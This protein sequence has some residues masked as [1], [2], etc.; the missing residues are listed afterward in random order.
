MGGG[1][2]INPHQDSREPRKFSSWDVRMWSHASN[3][4]VKLIT[5]HRS[6][7]TSNSG[8][9]DLAWEATGEANREASL[10]VYTL[11][12]Y[13]LGVYCLGQPIL[14]LSTHSPV[15]KEI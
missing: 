10:G 7:T 2:G 5:L 14:D 15:L 8:F 6:K 3:S 9:Y 4:V 13:S 11:G 12:V 1:G